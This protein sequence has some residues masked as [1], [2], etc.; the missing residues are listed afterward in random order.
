MT[1]IQDSDV[2]ISEVLAFLDCATPD[3]WLMAAREN[4]ALLLIDHAHCEKKAAANALS[5]I[6]CYPQHVDLVMK[7]SKLARE[8]LRHLE[9][10]L[11]MMK[12]LGIKF[13]G[14]SASRYAATLQQQVRKQEPE[15]LI[16]LLIIAA[17][18]EARSC[19]R[20]YRVIPHLNDKLAAFYQKLL[21]SEA[22]HYQLYLN[23]ANN[24]AQQHHLETR[25]EF[26]RELETEL[27]LKPDTQFRFH[28]GAIHSA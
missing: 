22:R 4:V 18:I 17:F 14:L 3:A 10:V 12:Q 16:D 1:T 25:I 23:F 7:L 9:M 11:Q 5:L 20:F 27:I 15:R 2:A 26:F 28:S 24:F 21:A 8:E 19:E 13:K 6:H